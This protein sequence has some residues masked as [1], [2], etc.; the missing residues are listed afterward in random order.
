MSHSTPN[1]SDLAAFQIRP[2][3]TEVHLLTDK[4]A[5]DQVYMVTLA[6]DLC[7]AERTLE[8]MEAGLPSGPSSTPQAGAVPATPDAQWVRAKCDELDARLHRL[9]QEFPGR[10]RNISVGERRPMPGRRNYAGRSSD[11]GK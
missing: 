10:L 4:H 6:E 3:L 8:S 11:E 2:A 9:E 1:L 7:R 5:C